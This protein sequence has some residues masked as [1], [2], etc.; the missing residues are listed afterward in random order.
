MSWYWKEV[1]NKDSA[2]DATKLGVGVS[3]FIAAVSALVAIVSLVSHSPI[4]GLNAWSLLDAGLFAVI[5]WRIARLSRAWSVVGLGL[6]VLEVV[7]S[8]SR[9]GVGF[10]VLSVIFVL[11]YINA[12]RGT[13]AYHKY[14]KIQAAE[15]SVVNSAD[16]NL[17][18]TQN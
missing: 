13:F 9:R 6:Y 3:Y 18:K 17:L 15:P 4:L 7:D 12:A 16:S 1:D 5:G 2:E 8:I 10:G 11:A 14:L